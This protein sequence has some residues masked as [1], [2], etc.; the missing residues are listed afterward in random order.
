MVQ[1]VA[2]ERA[3]IIKKSKILIYA[4]FDR[5]SVKFH[6]IFVKRIAVLIKCGS[7]MIR[8]NKVMMSE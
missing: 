8:L 6:G 1:N 2:Q 7:L 4:V 5:L 3:N